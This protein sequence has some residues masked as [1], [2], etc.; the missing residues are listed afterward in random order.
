MTEAV[1]EVA[2]AIRESKSVD[3]HPDLYI[4]VMKQGGFILEALMA[5]LSHLMDN[6]AQGVEFVAMADAP[7]RLNWLGPSLHSLSFLHQRPSPPS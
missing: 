1:K 7:R 6:M 5:A 2:I 3:V 4:A